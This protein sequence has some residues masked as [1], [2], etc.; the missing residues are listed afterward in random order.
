MAKLNGCVTF[1]NGPSQ[2]YVGQSR[3]RGKYLRE[4]L[5]VLKISFRS[6][7]VQ[8][9][10]RGDL[11]MPAPR[12]VLM[13]H[14]YAQ[15][16]NIFSKHLGALR[17]SMGKDIDLVFVDG[18]IVLH[19]VDPGGSSASTSLT[20]LGAS[21]ADMTSS[22]S[23]ATPRAWFKL[24]P[25]RTAAHRLENSLLYLR[26]ILQRDRYDGV[27]GFSQGA[28]MAV[29]LSALLERPHTYPPFLID[30]EAP[31]P[32]LKFCVCVSGFK[33][34]GYPST[35]IFGTSYSTPTLHILGRT[36]VV[37]IEEWSKALLNLAE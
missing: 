28:S 30:G 14:G 4:L 9:E 2:D 33:L 8:P 11:K 7:P 1:C 35:Q 10:L 17:E 21:E 29:L 20:V 23:S 36:D 5:V 24:N 27:F 13:L 32:P 12:K 34:P 16:A 6:P 31:H 25:E 3:T 19:P 18:P 26:D 37:V 15:N 22:D